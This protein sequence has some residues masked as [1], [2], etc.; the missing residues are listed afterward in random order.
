MTSVN[1]APRLSRPTIRGSRR[2]TALTSRARF[3]R[4]GSQSEPMPPYDRR[5]DEATARTAASAR[6][7]DR[8][9]CEDHPHGK[10]VAR[11]VVRRRDRAK[12]RCYLTAWLAIY[13]TRRRSPRRKVQ[14]HNKSGQDLAQVDECNDPD[15]TSED[16]NRDSPS[17]SIRYIPKL[18]EPTETKAKDTG[19]IRRFN[20]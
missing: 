3:H 13:R 6:L 1:A 12:R 2:R 18:S 9:S 5:G 20:S 16:H 19:A 4:F 11:L 15:Q 14:G 10:P 8:P 7:A 17:L